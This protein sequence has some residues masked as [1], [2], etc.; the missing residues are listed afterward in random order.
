MIQHMTFK[1]ATKTKFCITNRTIKGFLSSV[2]QHMP[3]QVTTCRTFSI[4]N[5]L[6]HLNGL[7]PVCINM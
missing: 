4:A 3:I 6:V 5:N 2:R 1:L 7:Y